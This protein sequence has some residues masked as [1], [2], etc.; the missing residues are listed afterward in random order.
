MRMINVSKDFDIYTHAYNTYKINSK[1][2]SINRKPQE[3][4]KRYERA[5]DYMTIYG[6]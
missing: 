6:I 5:Q 4:Q 1:W 2:Q 3:P